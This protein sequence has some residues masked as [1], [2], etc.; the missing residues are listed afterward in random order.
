MKTKLLFAK[1]AGM[2]ALQ[3]ERKLM[4]LLLI[5]SFTLAL[6]LKS[7]ASNNVEVI[8]HII[9]VEISATQMQLHDVKEIHMSMI[10]SNLNNVIGV[11]AEA[12][13]F[14]NRHVTDVKYTYKSDGKIDVDIIIRVTATL[15][16]VYPL[17]EEKEPRRFNFF[18]LEV[19]TVDNISGVTQNDQNVQVY[20]TSING[21]PATGDYNNAAQMP[22]ILVNPT[23][24][25]GENNRI[26][27]SGNELGNITTA[28]PNP[29]VDGMV[30][31]KS[32]IESLHIEQVQVFNSMGALILQQDFRSAMQGDVLINMTS[33]VKGVYFLRILTP[34]GETT[35][36]VSLIR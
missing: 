24:Q 1:V 22:S 8:N 33:L 36:R 25:K 3:F 10:I 2:A 13:D 6:I 18:N 20:R 26:T 7:N 15:A 30:R 14:R 16:S 17:P 21:I 28:Y 5:F 31:I 32:Q 35:K 9:P 23:V 12:I 29:S 27:L 19:I 34:L 4:H 11:R